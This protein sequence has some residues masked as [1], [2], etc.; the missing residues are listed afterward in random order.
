MLTSERLSD[1]LQR[2]FIS[3]PPMFE[4]LCLHETKENRGMTCPLRCGQKR[5]EYN[6]ELTG[7]MSDTEL[8]ECLRVEAVRILMGHPYR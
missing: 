7:R 1:I 4:V 8:E 3:E 5:L 2:W 6:P